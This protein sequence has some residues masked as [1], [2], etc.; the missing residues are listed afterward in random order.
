MFNLEQAIADW[1][2][3]MLAVGIETPIPLEELELHLREEMERQV[4]NGKD[5][6][7]AFETAVE[8]VGQGGSIA[9]EFLKINPYKS[10]N[11]IIKILLSVTAIVFGVVTVFPA[12][13]GLQRFVEIPNPLIII[14]I[15]GTSVATIGVCVL[16]HT[17]A[18]RLRRAKD[19]SALS[20]AT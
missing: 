16:L 19:R 11:T 17:L 6:Q 20:P 1:R 3:K 7:Q 8:K 12:L 10:M 15:L 18:T 9:N 2:R 14:L 4:G 13:A 5:D